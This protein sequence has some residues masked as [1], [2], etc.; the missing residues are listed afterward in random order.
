LRGARASQFPKAGDKSR[1]PHEPSCGTPASCRAVGYPLCRPRTDRSSKPAAHRH[2]RR[3]TP[4]VEAATVIAS[5]ADR[6]QSRP[7]G[8]RAWGGVRDRTGW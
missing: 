6:S 5:A 8:R 3:F 1:L 7:P 2:S 4:A